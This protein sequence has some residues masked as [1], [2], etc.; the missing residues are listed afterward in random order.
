M[1]R[2][3]L[4]WLYRGAHVF[5]A[6][7]LARARALAMAMLWT[8]VAALFQRLLKNFSAHQSVPTGERSVFLIWRIL[9]AAPARFAGP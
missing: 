8:M 1:I 2:V 4:P 7:A 9:V 6:C 5:P 3:L